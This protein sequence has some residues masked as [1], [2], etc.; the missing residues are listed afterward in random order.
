MKKSVLIMFHLLF[1]VITTSL[2]ITIVGLFLK[3]ISIA[4][5]FGGKVVDHTSAQLDAL[6]LYASIIILVVSAVIFYASYFSFRFFI[7][8]PIRFLWLCIALIVGDFV[9][10]LI[11]SLPSKAFDFSELLVIFIPFLYF[12]GFGFLFRIFIEWFN[13]RK[14]K[15]ELEKDK[16]ESQLELLKS[17]L[18][19][20]FLFNT[21]NNID[22]LILEE[23]KKASDYLKKLSEILRFMLYET[24]TESVPLS[25][26]I[27]HIKKYIE[28][29]KIRTSNDDYVELQIIG[30]AS[31]KYIA[32]MILVHFIENAFKYATNKKIKNAVSVKID[33]SDKF[34]SFMCKN[35]INSTDMTTKEK[36]GIGFQLIKQR[37]DLIYKKDYTLNVIEKDNW[38][39]VNLE[40]KIK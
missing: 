40:I 34:V 26:E 13:D 21:L 20:H 31:D 36:N 17:K 33:I 39:I 10:V 18:N 4:I 35:H 12:I 3:F 30:N 2:T 9:Y 27:D 6:K 37:L 7:R 28:L 29:Q 1:W 24:N 23:P 5:L 15:A 19:P 14:I 25:N 8:K 32:P 22:I 11:E 16:I 38:Y